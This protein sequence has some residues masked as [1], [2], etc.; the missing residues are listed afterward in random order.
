MC[1]CD[2]GRPKRDRPKQSRWMGNPPDRA[3]SVT[4]VLL[5]V[6]TQVVRRDR[7]GPL[8]TDTLTPVGTEG[9]WDPGIRSG[10]SPELVPLASIFRRE[11]ILNNVSQ[12]LE[13][14]EVTRIDI[15]EL[16]IFRPKRLALHEVL[17]R[18]TADYEIP[19]PP[20][21]CGQASLPRP[22]CNPPSARATAGPSGSASTA[23]W[24]RGYA[25]GSV[26]AAPGR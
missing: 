13:L 23:S 11:S 19:D 24:D 6:T 7:N 15:E 8:M 25:S 3:C 10:T 5:V 2:P 18:V 9:P 4:R 12:V 16:A 26:A 22:W 14:H 21:W 17:V 1:H 20:R